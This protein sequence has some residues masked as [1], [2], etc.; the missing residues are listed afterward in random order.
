[1]TTSYRF[2]DFE[3]DPIRFQLRR[4]GTEIPVPRQVF[5]LI[6]L[7]VRHRDR[8]VTKPEIL[9]EIWPDRIVTDASLTHAIA[10]ARRA[11]GDTP[12]AQAV[13]RTV[14]GRGYWWV[15]ETEDKSCDRPQDASAPPLLP[16]VG[17][18]RELAVLTKALECARDGAGAA[19]LI[20]G[21]SGIGK[22]RLCEEF[23]AL[24]RGLGCRVL[25][26]QCLEDEGAPV[27][28]PWIRI[29]REA[30][31]PSG[32][33]GIAA[34]P[35]VVADLQRAFPGL[36]LDSRIPDESE[37]PVGLFRV[38][39]SLWRVLVALASTSSC[40]LIVDDLHRADSFSMALFRLLVRHIGQLPILLVATSRQSGEPRK[41]E[42]ASL[43]RLPR[44]TALPLGGLSEAD[45]GE[46]VERLG[47]TGSEI[48][49][50]IHQVTGGS[51]FFLSQLLLPMRQQLGPGRAADEGSPRLPAT[52]RD[53]VLHQLQALSATQVALLGV[54]AV[55]GKS[56]RV[57]LLAAVGGRSLEEALAD[58][59][60]AESLGLI[61]EE[62][63]DPGRFNFRHLI[64][65]DSIYEALPRTLRCETHLKVARAMRA[66]GL[67]KEN[68]S[69]IA[70]H[71]LFAVPLGDPRELASA[72]EAAARYALQRMAYSEAVVLC[73]SA[74]RALGEGSPAD[75]DLRCELL[76][77]LATAQLRAGERE[78]G[79]QS[80]RQA[81]LLARQ[82]GSTY[83]LAE[84]ALA[85]APGFFSIETGVVDRQ[86]IEA[87]EDALASLPTGDSLLR[88]RLLGSLATALYWSP[89]ADRIRRLV[90]EA[91]SAAERLDS[92]DAHAYALAASYVATWSPGSLT[93]RLASARS[94]LELT[95]NSRD[96][97]LWLMARVLRAP[98][99]L[100][101]GDL[102]AARRETD[103][104]SEELEVSRHP[105]SQWYRPMY[106]AMWEITSGR[107]KEAEPLMREFLAVGDRFGDA[108]V[109]QTF[110]LQSAEIAWQRGQAASMISIV[111]ENVMRTPTLREWECALAFF[112][113]R[114]GRMEEARR[115]AW[116][117]VGDGCLGVRGRM[118]SAI[119]LA[120]LVE[121]ALLLQD[122][123]LAS[124]L[125]T[126]A[127][128]V[129]DRV[130]V[131]GYGVLCWGSF[132]RSLGHLATVSERW[133]LAVRHY[134]R[135]VDVETAIDAR[136][137]AARSRLSLAGVLQRRGGAKDRDAIGELL[138]S[139]CG[140]GG[141]LEL[142]NLID[143]ARSLGA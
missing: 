66:A 128:A 42:W 76:V 53:A 85:I 70:H 10:H 54:A 67:T 115:L 79:R 125:E 111:E 91:R 18:G 22:S 8:P 112:L 133:D 88:V 140:T 34:P 3:L 103:A 55:I 123:E 117:I 5:D 15:V 49:L 72:S 69:L 104:L 80:L 83:R 23:S 64:V 9:R 63:S 21:E 75:I 44:T 99:W 40:V 47:M 136:V 129:G 121:C 30:L 130:I 59:E 131:A 56:V 81:A 65:K 142:E 35:D 11:L 95:R 13:I 108:N 100:E 1:M 90:S 132:S 32:A 28:W 38:F 105:H 20:A 134:Q 4:E 19:V 97:D 120:G 50:E 82:S 2:L 118:N 138:R 48:S 89:E 141:E 17:R 60:A 107:Y 98:T 51:P 114:A 61:R 27:G 119:A 139:V 93:E 74:L 46:V 16:F 41:A 25:V 71:L 39:D 36:S 126:F 7:L 62:P 29:L 102:R 92:Q 135:A 86:L 52:L 143:E 68:A 31:T 78:S 106:R 58:L 73:E 84:A 14:H 87:L 110:L 6:L 26:G 122:R 116:S 24:A 12:D 43:L 94:L 45:V 33:R 127:Q 109:L 137:W 101:S 124:A 96:E 57:D 77:R 113:A 37:R